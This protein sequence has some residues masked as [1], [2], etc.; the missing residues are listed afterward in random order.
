[1]THSQTAQPH[2]TALPLHVTE[3]EHGQHGYWMPPGAHDAHVDAYS[4]LEAI[5]DLLEA[6]PNGHLPLNA[7]GLATVLRSAVLNALKDELDIE[8]IEDWLQDTFGPH[9]VHK[10]APL[11]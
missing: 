5:I 8:T 4:A 2:Y 9:T 10:V 3:G 7:L 11:R 1:M 6:H